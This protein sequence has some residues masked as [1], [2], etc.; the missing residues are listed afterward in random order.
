M[1]RGFL[2]TGQDNIKVEAVKHFKE[3]YKDQDSPSQLTKSE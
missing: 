2:L 3:L 1:N